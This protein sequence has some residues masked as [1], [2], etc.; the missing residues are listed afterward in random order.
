MGFFGSRLRSRAPNI[1]YF[2]DIDR[3]KAWLEGDES[4]P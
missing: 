1:E 4:A 2:K 3:A